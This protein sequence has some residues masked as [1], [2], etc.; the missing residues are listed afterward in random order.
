[1]STAR[2]EA[3]VDLSAISANVRAL[4]ERTQTLLMAVV[5]AD[6]YGHGLIEVAR[7]AQAG[8]AQWLGTALLQ[9]GLALRAA[10]LQGRIMSWLTPPDD[11]Y[12]EAIRVDID[13][14]ASSVESIR[15]IS[16]AAQ[17]VGKVARLHL[18]V[19]TGMTRGGVLGELEGALNAIKE[20][21]NSGNVY[22][23]GIWSHFARADEP[24]SGMNEKQR[25]AFEAAVARS[26]EKGLK[27]EIRHLANSA[28][29]LIDPLARYDMVR[30]G[31]AMYGLSPD[32][33]TLGPAHRFGLRPAMTLKSRLAL[34]KEVP[35]GVEVSYG[36][37][38]VIPSATTIGIL[39]LGYAD[40]IPRRGGSE[41]EV[42]SR[43]GRHKVLGRVCM[44]QLILDLGPGS[45]LRAGE[46]ITCFGAGAISA[47]DWGQ[48]SG[49]IGYE[50]VTRLGVRIPRV[51]TPDTH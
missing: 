21:I 36:G 37:T 24:E 48:W 29:T 44:D 8:G 18:E 13:L 3:I 5:K 30:C 17:R 1:M 32:V 47:D 12:D 22:F 33:T 2:A 51:Y 28:A 43:E 15:E 10:G 45:T 34:V 11:Q 25:S 19:D 31:I 49:T 39:P 41:L 27:P 42:E 16:Q 14:S 4:R 9:E 6:A 38:Y 7:A 23:A 20:G 26:Y 40:G 35:A 50:I 46:E